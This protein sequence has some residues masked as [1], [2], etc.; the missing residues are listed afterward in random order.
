MNKSINNVAN[1]LNI[2]SEQVNIVLD[3]IKEGSTVPFIARYRKSLTGG[4]DEEQIEKIN[5]IYIY[6]V[7]LNKR[8]DAIIKLMDEAGV[9]TEEIKGKIVSADRKSEVEAIYEPF[10]IGKKTKATEAIALGLEPLA[11]SIFTAE[12]QNFNPYNEARKYINDK[13]KDA[14]F[15]IEQAQLIIAQYISEDIDARKMIKENIFTHGFIRS[16][17]KRGGEAKDEKGRF[18]NYY[19]SKEKVSKVPNHRVMA[20]HR[21]E[22]L[23]IINV[24]LDYITSKIEYDLTNRYFKIRTTGKII[25]EA[26]LDSLKRLIFPSIEREIRSDLFNKA[27]EASIKLFAEN[28]EQMLL[29]P[30]VQGKTIL[31]IDPAFVSGCKVAVLGPSG[32]VLKI[33]LIT[34]TPPRKDISGSTITINKLIDQ[35]EVDIIVIGN[36][37]ASRE[38]EGFI[39]KLT[40]ERNDTVPF[41]VVS[42]VGASVYSASK[43]AID[44]FPDLSVE[45]RSAITIGRRFQDPLNELVKVDPKAIGV[46]QY[47]HDV[48]QKELSKSLDFKTHKVVN[49]VGVDANS[50]TK[51]ILSYV[52]G[53]SKKTAENFVNYRNEVGEFTNRKEV[54]KVKGL[55]AKAFEQSIGFIRIHTSKEFLDKTEIHPESYKLAKAIIKEL[56]IDVDNINKSLITNA[57]AKELADKFDSNEYD[58]QLILD[59]IIA[60]GKDIRSEKEGLILKTD[61][62]E[63]K[64]ISEGMTLEGT[65]QNITDFGAF[66]YI[67]IK[68]AVL[69]HISKLSDKFVSHPSDIVKTGERVTLE[70]I[71][72][73]KERKRI[74]GQLVS[75]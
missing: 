42:E 37:T 39:A 75:K 3:M 44:E 63:F 56:K 33:D 13:V 52:A 51:E 45:Q 24:S 71:S 49:M 74:Q 58:V 15:A 20:L 62:L 21:A 65:V 4:L 38:T 47:Q 67:G 59:A 69:I 22:D 43:I 30:A 36:G 23:K 8:K 40:K 18:R 16:K 28:L 41:A 5:D 10:K 26:M 50:A 31:A 72:I 48:N 60:P 19:E 73:D 70:V 25:R 14:D 61:V 54:K 1:K 34:P 35:Y 53:L 11:K 2:K 32:N 27:E 6:D 17:L 7:N 66:I 68:E 9:L 12:D 55:G 57:S 46:G 29:A 64:D